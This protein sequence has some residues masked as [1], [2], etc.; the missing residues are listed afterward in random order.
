M[1]VL[2]RLL[3]T[4]MS[5]PTTHAVPVPLSYAIARAVRDGI[6]LANTRVTV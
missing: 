3:T 6:L 5:T 4:P 1:E 2:E